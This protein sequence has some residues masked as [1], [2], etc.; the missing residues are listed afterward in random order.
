MGMTQRRA[1]EALVSLAKALFVL[2]FVSLTTWRFDIH[3]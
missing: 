2:Q 1:L 3:G